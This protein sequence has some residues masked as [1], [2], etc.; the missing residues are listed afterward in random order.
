MIVPLLPKS[1]LTAV[2]KR[3][4]D[5]S[6]PLHVDIFGRTNPLTLLIFRLFFLII[7]CMYIPT[8]A[9]SLLEHS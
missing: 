5:S 1:W 8:P 2:L 4:H 7:G 6:H 9:R 3:H